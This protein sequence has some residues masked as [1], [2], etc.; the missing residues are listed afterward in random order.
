[1]SGVC[2]GAFVQEVQLRQGFCVCCWVLGDLSEA[3]NGRQ[4]F[5]GGLA[6]DVYPGWLVPGVLKVY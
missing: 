2:D 6:E 5:Y 1:M 4:A 3:F